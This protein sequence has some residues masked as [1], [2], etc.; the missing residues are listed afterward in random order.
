LKVSLFYLIVLASTLATGNVSAEPESYLSVAAGQ[1]GILDEGIKD[2]E[3]FKLEYRFASRLSWQLAP[4]I[5]MARSANDASFVFAWL[6]KDFAVSEHWII[7]PTFGLGF[8]DDGVD[9]KL[10]S[11]LEF[12]SGI[13]SFY[14]FQNKLRLGLELFHLSNGGIA[15][16][17][18]GTET[19]FI[20]LSFPL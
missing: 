11:E 4:G 15:D 5:G 9:V 12:R 1:V 16:R 13:K 17:N 20:S 7:T 14:Q 3:V 8:F 2:P 19:A 6:E 18:P 10:G